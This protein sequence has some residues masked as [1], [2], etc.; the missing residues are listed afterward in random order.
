[1]TITNLSVQLNCTNAKEL[2]EEIYSQYISN[3]DNDNH[4]QYVAAALY[5]AC[6]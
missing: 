4:P 5:I 3:L 1:M 6:K 2:A